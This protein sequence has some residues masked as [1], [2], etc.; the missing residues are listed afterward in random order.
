[1][2]KNIVIL[3]GSPR[4]GATTDRLVDAFIEGAEGAGN[5]VA[6]FRV[7]D[8]KIGGCLGC[9]CC[10][11]NGGVCVQKDDMPSIL[12]ALRKAEV[13]VL[14]SPVYYFGFTAQLKSAV[15]RTF[16][17]L[18]EGVPVK[19]AALLMTC[20]A[21]EGAAASSVS[22][23]RQISALQKWEEAGIVTAPHLH[24]PEEIVGRGELEQARLLGTKI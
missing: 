12:D 10:F 1:M 16:A 20:G 4:K 18:K 21:G 3:S 23:F 24:E 11:A 13:L 9:R 5:S 7:A 22:M 17:L 6:C 8:M 14:A 2:G 19:R 15:D